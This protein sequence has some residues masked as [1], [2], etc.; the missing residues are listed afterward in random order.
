M[1][2]KGHSVTVPNMGLSLVRTDFL[3][4]ALTRMPLSLTGSQMG[5]WLGAAALA[6]RGRIAYSP[7]IQG[8]VHDSPWLD[9]RS[10]TGRQEIWRLCLKQF[11]ISGTSPIHG[12]AGLLAWNRQFNP[13]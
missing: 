10:E 11:D 2:L 3:K 5:L 7:L 13:A 8:Q 12:M 4:R 9:V 1:A 6:W